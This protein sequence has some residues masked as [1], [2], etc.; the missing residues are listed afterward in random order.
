MRK[1]ILK[2][3]KKT[4]PPIEEIADTLYDKQ[5]SF[6]DYEI[7]KVIYSSDKTKRFIILKSLNGFYKYT[8]EEI[9]VWDEDEWKYCCNDANAYPAFWEPRDKSSAYSFFGTEN[10]AFLSMKQESEYILHFDRENSMKIIEKDDWKFSVDVEK[11]KAYYKTHSLCECSNCRNFYAQIEE[12]LP[13]LKEFLSAFGVDISKPDESSSIE[14]ENSIDYLSVDYT[15]CGEIIEAS[16]YEID[17]YDNLFLSIVVNDDFVCPNEQTGKFFTFSVFQIEL[18]WVLDEPLH[19]TVKK[20]V[21][22]KSHGIF[23]K[24]SRSR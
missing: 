1:H 24:K 16:K 15:V 23:K 5:L 21:F 2:K 19:P 20:R 11:T 4:I 10:E 7:V 22:D 9:C 18:P 12:K 13:K 14:R 17:I 3:N 6:T 8:Y